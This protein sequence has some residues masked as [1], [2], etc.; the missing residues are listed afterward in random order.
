MFDPVPICPKFNASSTLDVEHIEDLNNFISRVQS[1]AESYKVNYN[2]RFSAIL[3]ICTQIKALLENKEAPV[4]PHSDKE[5]IPEFQNLFQLLIYALADNGLLYDEYGR[6]IGIRQADDEY[7]LDEWA[8]SE[9]SYKQLA[10]AMRSRHTSYLSLKK[11]R[12]SLKSHVNQ[13]SNSGDAAEKNLPVPDTVKEALSNLL[14]HIGCNLDEKS[15]DAIASNYYHDNLLMR[16][17]PLYIFF[18][19]TQAN[20]KG[21]SAKEFLSFLTTPSKVFSDRTEIKQLDKT[22]KFSLLYYKI[23][24]MT[25]VENIGI[26]AFEFDPF[27]ILASLRLHMS[28]RITKVQNVRIANNSLLFYITEKTENIPNVA[29][30]GIP[31]MKIMKAFFIVWKAQGTDFTR[32][33]AM[34]KN[35]MSSLRLLYQSGVISPITSIP[36]DAKKYTGEQYNEI[37]AHILDN[38]F[39]KNI[40]SLREIFWL[41]SGYVPPHDFPFLNWWNAARSVDFFPSD[42]YT[43]CDCLF[44]RFW[45]VFK[46]FYNLQALPF[47]YSKGLFLDILNSRAAFAKKWNSEM[48]A[49]FI[50]VIT[51]PEAN[52][53][54]K[55]LA[56]IK[57]WYDK[58]K[59]TKTSFRS[60]NYYGD[61]IYTAILSDC[62]SRIGLHIHEEVFTLLASLNASIWQI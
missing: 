36:T 39:E 17:T 35:A 31:I 25:S 5:P 19:A 18:I 58:H 13:F 49:A 43:L 20:G 8:L 15:I 32:G 48:E 56:L 51:N 38:Y 40:F 3:T 50:K 1:Y 16:Y 22:H 12:A 33:N 23:E 29:I 27:R 11:L 62:F 53:K 24:K 21:Y 41:L 52:S 44:C 60:L 46:P 14:K 9:V 28:M 34:P 10:F 55:L 7:I 37:K 26:D 2:D 54:K 57:K 61:E 4:W 59:T 42:L 6:W 47:R 30:S 45:K